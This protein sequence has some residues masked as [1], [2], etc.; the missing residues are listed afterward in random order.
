M[1]PSVVSA[2]KSGASSP[3]RRVIVSPRNLDQVCRDSIL[4]PVNQWGDDPKLVALLGEQGAAGFRALFDGFPE[5]VGVLWALR[6][7]DGQI[8]DF[9]FGYGNPSIMRS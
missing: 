4:V 7:A 2:S 9:V 6:T 8:E 3:I 5:L 1:R